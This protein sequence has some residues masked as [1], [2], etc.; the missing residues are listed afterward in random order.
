MKD[1]VSQTNEE[2][3][4]K[5]TEK[6]SRAEKALPFLIVAVVSMAVI[7]TCVLIAYYQVYKSSKQNANILE[8]VYASSYFSMVDNVN[9]L[10]IDIDKFSNAGT[11]D[12]KIRLMQRMKLDCNYILA[13]LSTLPI[14][15]DNVVDSTK[16]FN[17]INGVCEAYS[18]KLFSG[19][20]L[21]SEEEL[22]FDRIAL[23]LER[24]KE[25]FN[26]QNQGMYDTGF[27]F[28]DA[29]IFDNTGMNELSS[30]MGNLTSDNV[31][32]PAM[33]F[34]GPFST[35]L[36]TANV[37]GLGNTEY[38]QEE[39]VDYIKNIIYEGKDV[40]VTYTGDTDGDV[41]TYNYEIVVDGDRFYT[42]VSKMGRLLITLS[43]YAEAG[44]PVI[45]VERAGE[46]AVEL[47]AR[48]GFESMGIVW[49]E[50]NENVAYINLAPIIDSVIYYP[51]LV[52]VKVDLT[53]Q[54]IIGFE[55]LNYA[56]NHTD[57]TPTFDLTATECE[58]TLGFDYEIVDVKRAIIRLDGGSEVSV[59]EY[60]LERID[61]DYFY[62]IN[63][64]NKKIE[65]ILKLVNVKNVEKLI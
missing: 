29:G 44:D 46:L 12:M 58:G 8:G 34:D 54:R 7:M 42:Q 30:S 65:K 52:K 56:L 37:L 19:G 31:E 26:I 23:V 25:N 16:F 15:H 1:V 51:D 33:I 53:G 48:A 14:S 32:Y 57:R 55:S 36:E 21:T 9:N 41:A 43:G 2:K 64:V 63:A 6:K 27:N 40:R 17:Q 4:I 62:Y 20:D 11:K 60:V 47:A 50:Q 49:H 38:T 35:A 3:L 18:T 5:S 28:V 22:L 61:G 59:Y 45:S 24:I 10:S 13:G 39:C